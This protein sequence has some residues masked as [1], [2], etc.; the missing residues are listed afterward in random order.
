MRQAKEY[1]NALIDVEIQRREARDVVLQ[2]ITHLCEMR[3][4]VLDALVQQLEA[5]QSQ[6]RAKNRSAKRR[7]QTPEIKATIKALRLQIREARQ[8]LR[9]SRHVALTPEAEAELQTIN[10]NASQQRRALRA[11]CGLYWGTYLKAE[12]AAEMACKEAHPR[13]Q[14]FHG[15]GLIGVQLQNGMSLSELFSGQ[16]RKARLSL[17][18]GGRKRGPY[19]DMLLRMGTDD[20]PQKLPIWARISLF[21]H[22]PL[23]PQG[24]I[25]WIVL[26]ATRT[27]TMT[28]WQ[29]QFTVEQPKEAWIRA[30]PDSQH[31]VGVDL[32]WRRMSDGR[33][34]VAT[35]KGSDGQEGHLFLEAPHVAQWDKVC[36]LQEIRTHHFNTFRTVLADWIN[37][38]R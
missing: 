7:S 11:E 30:V 4:A 10:N 27:G 29:I 15:E 28:R 25:K 19:G 14:G 24:S 20:S 8:Q 18:P 22:R 12:Y 34:R 1:Q 26:T 31:T 35:W 33:L 37:Q 17:R 16:N 38:W 36:Q 21:Y 6:E 23:P 2:P 9:A 5:I 13:H 32:N 3:L